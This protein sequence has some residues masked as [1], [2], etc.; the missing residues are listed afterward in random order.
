[1]RMVIN[2]RVYDTETARFIVGY[3]NGLSRGN[4][5]FLS[6]DLYVT[7]KGQYFI[8]ATGGPLTI[9]SESSGNNI[10]AGQGSECGHLYRRSIRHHGQKQDTTPP[11]DRQG[12][13]EAHRHFE[14]NRHCR[15]RKRKQRSQDAGGQGCHHGPGKRG[16]ILLLDPTTSEKRYRGSGFRYRQCCALAR[17]LIACLI[18]ML[19]APLACLSFLCGQEAISPFPG[20]ASL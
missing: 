20:L 15:I 9:Y 2:K 18:K 4:F 6:E 19:T 12:G 8:H 5:K 11:G 3:H 10:V 1:M 17:G 14:R 13:Q 16:K 7:K